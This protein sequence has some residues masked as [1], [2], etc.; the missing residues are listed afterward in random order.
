MK[1][2]I[3]DNP[4]GRVAKLREIPEKFS[5][6]IDALALGGI[7]ARYFNPSNK[8]ELLRELKDN[9]V[10]LV[11]SSAFGIPDENGEIQVIHEI[12]DDL[13]LAYIGSDAHVLKLALNKPLL[14]ME[15]KK[16]QVNTPAW[17]YLENR[18]FRKGTIETKLNTF[19]TFPCI[20]K[21][22]SS[23][24]SRGIDI[25]SIAENAEELRMKVGEILPEFGSVLVEEYL[26]TAEDFQEIT[27]AWI[28]NESSV[29]IMPAEITVQLERKYPVISTLDKEAHLTWVQQLE[30]D[31]QKEQVVDFSRKA[32]SIIAVRDYARLDIIR[33][34]GSYHTIEINGQPMIPDRWFE[35]CARG[36]G[37]NQT[38]YI[39]AIFLSGI[40]R[41]IAQGNITVYI[42]PEMYKIIPSKV[43]SILLS[44][45]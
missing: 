16:H 31:G 19:S 6:M 41:S 36:V 28:G 26:G 43:I 1:A 7:L 25:T 40:V 29:L 21:P 8:S 12:L 13:G 17:I 23:G 39:N 24:N 4:G 9:P 3:L 18:D 10:D 45:L 14:K 2:L 22:A 30:D 32:F 15:W 11:F 33:S 34:Q 37:L 44:A 20:V 27:V 35:A 5:T 42:P 38:Q